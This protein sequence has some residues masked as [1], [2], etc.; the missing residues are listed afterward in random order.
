MTHRRQFDTFTWSMF[1]VEISADDLHDF[2]FLDRR[3]DCFV[4]FLDVM[5]GVA[6]V[7]HVH[8]LQGDPVV[9]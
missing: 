5:V 8:N 4:S 7:W 3:E 1:S 6:T 9:R 2:L